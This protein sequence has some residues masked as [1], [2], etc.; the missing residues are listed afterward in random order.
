MLLGH[1]GVNY[2]YLPVTTISN[3][4]SSE[5]QCAP[6]VPE[7]IGGHLQ[8]EMVLIFEGSRR[9]ECLGITSA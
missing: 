3:E 7:L 2:F 1:A 4:V 5:H 8:D 6:D 9:P